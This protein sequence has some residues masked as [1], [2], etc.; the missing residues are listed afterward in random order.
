[1]LNTYEKYKFDL[2]ENHDEWCKGGPQF[3]QSIFLNLQGYQFEDYFVTARQDIYDL[4]YGLQAYDKK[5]DTTK[6]EP[7]PND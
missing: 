6:A 5:T 7:K 1:M 3:H 2:E 4:M